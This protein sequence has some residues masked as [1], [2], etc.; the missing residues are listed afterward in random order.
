M[1]LKQNSTSLF[2]VLKNMNDDTSNKYCC[3]IGLHYVNK[4]HA[5]Y[6]FLTKEES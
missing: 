3:P 1:A 6:K 2:P 5:E 4:S